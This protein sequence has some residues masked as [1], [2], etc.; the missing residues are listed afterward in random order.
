MD[1]NSLQDYFSIVIVGDENVGKTSIL[2]KFCNNKFSF[3]K[4]KQKSIEIYKKTLELNG[5]EF[6]LKLWDTQY[7]ESYFKLNKQIYERADCIIFTCSINNKD[8]FTNLGN[9]YQNL[10]ENIDLSSKQMMIL[11]NKSDLDDEREVGNDE[12]RQK[13]EEMDIPFFEI[14]ALN[15]SGID[16]AFNSL[17]SKVVSNTYKN[18]DKQELKPDDNNNSSG[19]C[20]Q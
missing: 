20:A 9:W 15:G 11:A 13:A 7:N 16:E 4:K 12:I 6:R 5:T 19:P 8:S 3:S 1:S 17:V 14:S 10:S 18:E 2:D